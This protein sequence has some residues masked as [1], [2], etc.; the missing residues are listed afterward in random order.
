VRDV[1]ELVVPGL[2]AERCL[3]V[4]EATA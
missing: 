2:G 4:I 1:I 3:I